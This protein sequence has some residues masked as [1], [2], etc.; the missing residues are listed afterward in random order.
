MK[1]YHVPSYDTMSQKAANLISAQIIL[2][3][4]SVLGLATGS[5]PIG[6]YERLVDKHNNG[7]LDCGGL[8]TFNLD[9]YCGLSEDDPQSY[10]YFM[11]SHLF[12]KVNIN[13]EKIHLPDASAEDIEQECK[14]Y[15]SQIEACGIDLQLLGIGNN[16]HIG[17]NEPG[18][19]FE[20]DTHCVDLDESTILANARFFDDPNDVPRKAVTMGMKSIMLAKKIL[21]VAN[22]EA[23]KAILEKSLYGPITPLVPASIL[24]L[25]P[26]LTVVWSD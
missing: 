11:K 18:A 6:V 21:L 4:Q 17:F 10:H 22:G 15:D 16:G 26:D 7:E 2:Y 14:R 8:T 25:H 19:V 13:K 20:G 12:S 23:K 5:T 3:P 1:V 9:E 24:Q